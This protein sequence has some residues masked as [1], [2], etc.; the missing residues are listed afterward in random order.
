[1]YPDAYNEGHGSAWKGYFHHS[2]C[3]HDFFYFRFPLSPC[4][5]DHK[6]TG[7]SEIGL[8]AGLNALAVWVASCAVVFVKYLQMTS[9]SVLFHYPSSITATI[10]DCNSR[11]T[12]QS[13]QAQLASLLLTA[14]IRLSAG[15]CHSF[16][17][18]PFCHG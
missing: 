16:S 6:R 11:G 3:A 10:C 15:L 2:C 18:R 14:D 1:M 17:Q 7:K 13:N 9:C 12:G 4:S 8:I 5:R